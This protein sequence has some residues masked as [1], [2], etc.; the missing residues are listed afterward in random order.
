MG[1][2]NEL[3][4]VLSALTS[5]ERDVLLLVAWDGLSPAESAAVLGITA[6]AARARLSR[7]RRRAQAVLDSLVVEP[8]S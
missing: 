2:R 8:R 3:R 7:A 1:R 4:Q 6:E 5:D